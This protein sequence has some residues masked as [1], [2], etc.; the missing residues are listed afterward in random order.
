[1]L[2][3]SIFLCFIALF[4]GIAV[5][6]DDDYVR[7]WTKSGIRF[8]AR[9]VTMQPRLVT[10]TEIQTTT[11][12]ATLRLRSL[13]PPVKRGM[14]RA[15]LNSWSYQDCVADNDNLP[16]LVSPFPYQ[17][18]SEEVSNAACMDFC[19]ERG[20]SL[21]A[22]QNGNECWCGTVS[23]A[24][25]FYPVDKSMCNIPCAAAT[26]EMY[27]GKGSLSVFTRASG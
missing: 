1:M 25:N 19:D 23:Q 10:V 9:S 2:A 20:S 7:I 12:T 18:S 3:Q 15:F 16:A 21:A 26:G 6:H 8:Q 17:L 5:A 11:R 27:G 4:T 14:K 13:V 24:S 22:T